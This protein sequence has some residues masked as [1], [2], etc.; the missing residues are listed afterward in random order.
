MGLGGLEDL[1]QLLRGRFR[2]RPEV[3][4]PD[5]LDSAACSLRL[6]PYGPLDV[7]AVERWKRVLSPVFL[8]GPPHRG[9]EGCV[10]HQSC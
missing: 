9:L 6:R 5:V 7:L 10:I 8:Q 3:P 4:W 1:C 2:K